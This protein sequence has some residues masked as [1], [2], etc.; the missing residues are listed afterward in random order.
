MQLF[1]L[2]LPHWKRKCSLHAHA[3]PHIQPLKNSHCTSN[4]ARLRAIESFGNSRIAIIAQYGTQLW[5]I[6]IGN[7]RQSQTQTGRLKGKKTMK[8]YYCEISYLCLAIIMEL[9]W[10]FIVICLR[11]FRSNPNDLIF[12]I[13]QSKS[14][15][16]RKCVDLFV[17][18]LQ[19]ISLDVGERAI[20][21]HWFPNRP[22][23]FY[24]QLH[25]MLHLDVSVFS[26]FTSNIYNWPVKMIESHRYGK[27]ATA[28]RIVA[29][30]K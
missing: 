29:K 11:R 21:V 3:V 30:E 22:T 9:W 6:F 25:E 28:S 4:G 1:E 5:P 27:S 16:H 24:R 12:V 26:V 2:P 14:K 19:P 17:L 13:F 7:C 23:Q 15:H 10:C 20:N 8:K 18:E